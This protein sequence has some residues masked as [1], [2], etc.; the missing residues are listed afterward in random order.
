MRDALNDVAASGRVNEP[1]AEGV[2][3]Y[4]LRDLD[5]DEGSRTRMGEALKHTAVVQRGLAVARGQVER[6]HRRTFRA[7]D[8]DDERNIL[9]DDSGDEQQHIE[10]DDSVV[11]AIVDGPLP[12]SATTRAGSDGER[13]KKRKRVD[14][15]SVAKDVFDELEGLQEDQHVDEHAYNMIA[16]GLK[17]VHELPERGEERSWQRCVIQQ[18]VRTPH[19]LHYAP[20]EV[21]VY[22]PAFIRR[23]VRAKWKRT[24]DSH[25][26]LNPRW[27]RNITRYYVRGM[28]RGSR[29]YDLTDPALDA[30]ERAVAGNFAV[31]LLQVD[32]NSFAQAVVDR[33]EKDLHVDLLDVFPY[34]VADEDQDDGDVVHAQ[35][36]A[37]D[38]LS[39]A[40]EMI[41]AFCGYPKVENKREYV[42]LRQWAYEMASDK[43]RSNEAFKLATGTEPVTEA[44]AIAAEEGRICVAE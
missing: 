2:M 13:P 26:G 41:T 21:D 32:A 30:T 28:A 7:E 25:F 16:K 31:I 27:V 22:E 14:V 17:R 1:V 43:L 18:V 20:D 40:P 15:R 23:L 10:E 12:A 24:S 37:F 29:F 42:V 4:M 6:M 19:A 3:E 5:D 33:F 11:N 35:S 39:L 8:T 36:S 44:E 38:V 9:S 34:H